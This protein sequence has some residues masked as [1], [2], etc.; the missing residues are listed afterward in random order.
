M[1]ALY[2]VPGTVFESG[3]LGG[4]NKDKRGLCLHGA[5]ILTGRG[6]EINHEEGDFRL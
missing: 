2:Y 3:G 6:A 4:N 1:G 5:Y